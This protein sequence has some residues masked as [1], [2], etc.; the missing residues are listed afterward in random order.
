[1]RQ[2]E[3]VRSPFRTIADRGVGKKGGSGFAVV[4]LC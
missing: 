1:M 3:G 4:F 2:L